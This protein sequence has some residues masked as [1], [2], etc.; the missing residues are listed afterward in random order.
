LDGLK[1]IPSFKNISFPTSK[2]EEKGRKRKKREE[3]IRKKTKNEERRR[4][5][6]KV[7]IITLF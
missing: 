2:E 3:K 5:N 1:S 6:V 4:K 7:T